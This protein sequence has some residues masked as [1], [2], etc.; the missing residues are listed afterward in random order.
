MRLLIALLALT[1]SFSVLSAPKANLWPYWNV[2]NEQS[3]DTIS[4]QS[5]QNI[6]DEYLVMEGQHTLFR[7][8]AVSKKDKRLLEKYITMLSSLTPQ[9]YSKDEQ[10]SYWVNLYN[11]LTVNLILDNYPTKSITKIGSFFSFGPW[12]QNIISIDGKEL[13]LNDIEHR[14]LRPIWNDPRTHYAL[15]CASLGCPNLQP[16]AFTAENT[17]RNLEKAANGFINS[18]KGALVSSNTLR[19]SSIYEWF[20]ADFGAEEDLFE[21]LSKYRGELSGYDGK[22]NYDYDWKLNGK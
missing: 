11:A 17:E 16:L 4:H 14:I 15:N 6:L 8:S 1:T 2:S 7:Y 18:D 21:H 3:T 9:S 13:T 19:L 12:G 20:I 22:V 10:Y 5:W